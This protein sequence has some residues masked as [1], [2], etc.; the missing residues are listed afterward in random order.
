MS[1][2]NTYITNWICFF[3]SQRSTS[4]IKADDVK[5]FTTPRKLI[6]SLQ[7][8]DDF[9]IDLSEKQPRRFRSPMTNKFA[10]TPVSMHG[11]NDSPQAQ[12]MNCEN[13]RDKFASGEQF[14]GSPESV[15]STEDVSNFAEIVPMDKPQVKKHHNSTKRV[16]RGLFVVLFAVFL[17][18]LVIGDQEEYYDVVPT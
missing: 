1:N 8:E 14:H 9:D 13:N 12:R 5:I 15:S 7:D 4:H 3:V 6:R 11:Q 17:F 18:L 10:W 16:V 2:S